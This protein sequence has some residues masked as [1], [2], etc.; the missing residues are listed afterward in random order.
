MSKVSRG[1]TSHYKYKE[2]LKLAKGYYGH[3]KSCIKTAKQAVDKSLS[4]K[5]KS[6]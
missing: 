2:I 6:I 3:R 5:Y 4:Y 1:L